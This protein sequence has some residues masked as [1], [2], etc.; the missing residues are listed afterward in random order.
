MLQFCLRHLLK[1][2]NQVQVSCRHLYSNRK[3][4]PSVLASAVARY[5]A[6]NREY[7]LVGKSIQR[8]VRPPPSCASTGK[9]S[10]SLQTTFKPE[11]K[12]WIAADVSRET[13]AATV[14]ALP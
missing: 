4:R 8:S 2:F 5:R 14:T 1:A 3:N 7:Q 10:L 13:S 11:P 6:A 9:P 12:L